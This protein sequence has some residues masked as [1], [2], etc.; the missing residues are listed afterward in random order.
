MEW[1]LLAFFHRVLKAVPKETVTFE[2][3]PH[4]DRAASHGDSGAEG[5]V[6]GKRSCQCKDPVAEGNWCAPGEQGGRQAG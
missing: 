4:R 6:L 5:S 2:L 3:R 1:T